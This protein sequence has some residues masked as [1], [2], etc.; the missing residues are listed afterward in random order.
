MP[1]PLC[2][3]RHARP[4]PGRHVARM[5]SPG[6]REGSLRD[7]LTDQPHAATQWSPSHC[8]QLVSHRLGYP[9]MSQALTA[10]GAPQWS[11]HLGKRCFFAAAATHLVA[12]CM[13]LNPVHLPHRQLRATRSHHEGVNQTG[14]APTLSIHSASAGAVPP[15][16]SPPTRRCHLGGSTRCWKVGR[17]G[18]GGTTTR[19]AT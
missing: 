9:L 19:H 5:R 1:S 12:R 11:R 2:H 7:P 16:R 6:V 17:P 8:P 3:D 14:L 10:M 18:Y 13:P 15:G 4:V